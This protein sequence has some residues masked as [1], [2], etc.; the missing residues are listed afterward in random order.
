M[1]GRP[2]R[3]LRN[4]GLLENPLTVDVRIRPAVLAQLADRYKHFRSVS[5]LLSPIKHKSAVER[6]ANSKHNFRLVIHHE[7]GAPYVNDT[8]PFATPGQITLLS[9]PSS[10]GI[11]EASDE[12]DP[13][14]TLDRPPSLS[15]TPKQARTSVMTGW[16]Y[17]HRV[18][19]SS[20]LL[21]SLRHLLYSLAP[22]EKKK[23]RASPERAVLHIWE[24]RKPN[25]YLPRRPTKKLIAAGQRLG[26]AREVAVARLVASGMTNAKA[27]RALD[28][29]IQNNTNSKM[30]REGYSANPSQSV[31][32]WF[33]ICELTNSEVLL[34]STDKNRAVRDALNAFA[35][36]VNA[37]FPPFYDT[38]MAS[39]VGGVITI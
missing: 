21:D 28:T 16:A 2:L 8:K 20:L 19:D 13:E 30:S 6:F 17:M 4:L 31:A 32:D 34:P 37:A 25:G 10:L 3:R 12:D 23:G 7:R 1:A 33:P 26:D 36:D 18:G 11:E 39:L 35:R 24:R 22:W 38:L 29:F 15:E 27:E 14:V 5:S 9:I